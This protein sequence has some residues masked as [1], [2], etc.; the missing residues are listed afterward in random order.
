MLDSLT[1]AA[2]ECQKPLWRNM[3]RMAAALHERSIQPA[4]APFP[5]DWE[6]FGP[7]YHS[8]PAFGHWDI[9]HIVLDTM[10]H[11]PAHARNQ[12]INNLVAQREDG[13][14][15]GTIYVRADGRVEFNKTW[16]HPP[17]WEYAAQKLADETED[18]AIID[19]CFEPLI[20]QL[21]WFEKN[22]RAEIEGFYYLDIIK[23]VW[24]SGVDEGVRFDEVQTGPFACV[25]CTS[26]VYWMCEHAERWARMLRKNP[27]PYAKRTEELRSFIRDRLYEPDSGFFY[28]I[29]A[30][31]AP[32]LRRVSFE[33]MWPV[34]VGVATED[35]ATSVIDPY[36]MN[37]RRFFAYHPITS[38]A[39][40]DPGFELRCWRGPAWN[41]MT[42]WAAVGCMRYNRPDA[43]RALL[44]H[45]LDATAEQCDKTGKIWE[46][47]HPHG[48]SPTDVK[49]K[50]KIGNQPCSDYISHNPLFAMVLLW[51]T[52]GRMQK[53]RK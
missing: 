6:S 26:H 18:T 53:K 27:E 1:R 23:R 43:A 33:G 10:H 35:Q 16:G 22:R 34:V 20:R 45:A 47:Y 9:V 46:F 13:M 12:I 52:A 3:L 28:D 21:D 2:D 4:C 42:Y 48:G 7:G 36:L 24:E 31:E 5:F 29:W 11:E 41:S 15:P 17:L 25:D 37:P 8:H 50:I 32:A 39:M 40:D 44:E 19:H 38:V 49:R 14:V 51:E 30:V